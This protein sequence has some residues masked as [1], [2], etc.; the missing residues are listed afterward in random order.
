MLNNNK[1]IKV[2]LDT[3]NG[4]DIDD[5]FTLYILLND[6]KF[7]VIGIISSYLNTP[8]RARQIRHVLKLKGR[9]DIPVFAGCGQT[10]KGLHD[11]PSNIVFWQYSE[12]LDKKE[13]FNLKDSPDGEL[14]I[15][16]LIESAKKYKDELYIVGVAPETTIAKAIEKNKEAFKNC[17]F[18]LMGGSFYQNCSEWNIECDYEAAKIVATSDL[19]IH[20]C[21]LDVT[22]S[23]FLPDYIYQQFINIK[24]D[25]YTNYLIETTKLWN[26]FSKRNPTLHDPLTLLSTVYDVVQYREMNVRLDINL[27]TRKTVFE[28]CEADKDFH[29]V[30]VAYSIDIQRTFKLIFELLGLD[31]EILLKETY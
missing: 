28:S 8:L 2:I 25:E 24:K 10:I 3:D 1:T 22:R 7:E 9:E 20:Y 26:S 14:A 27:D 12:V 30:K 15:D 13:Y 21:G 6:P 5:L 19:D 11:R 17:H 18:Y 29:S 31:K 23:T 4:D 16:F